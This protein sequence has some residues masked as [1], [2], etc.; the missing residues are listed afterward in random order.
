MSP[1]GKPLPQ[2]IGP[3]RPHAKA[4]LRVSK[5]AQAATLLHLSIRAKCDFDVRWSRTKS[6]VP[7][8]PRIDGASDFLVPGIPDSNLNRCQPWCG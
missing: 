2:P 6:L 1:P 7:G 4:M 8:V 5:S 3:H